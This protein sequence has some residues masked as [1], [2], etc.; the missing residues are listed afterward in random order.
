[1]A[2]F[3]V[4]FA[5]GWFISFLLTGEGWMIRRVFTRI[6]AFALVALSLYLWTIALP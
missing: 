3:I 1:M 5:I 6:A 2:A 4:A